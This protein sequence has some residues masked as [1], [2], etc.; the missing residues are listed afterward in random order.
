[1]LL[2][3]LFAFAHH[4]AKAGLFS[5]RMSDHPVTLLFASSTAKNKALRATTKVTGSRLE[6]CGDDDF[7]LSSSGFVFFLGVNTKE[8]AEEQQQ[9][10][11]FPAKS[12]RG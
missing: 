8:T 9:N 10:H 4:S 2:L 1:M 6:A 12:T 3:L 7:V 11:W 5:G